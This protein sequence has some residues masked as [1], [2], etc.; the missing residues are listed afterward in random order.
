M[1]G[2]LSS[3][4]LSQ[5]TDDVDS[6]IQNPE[7]LAL[8]RR[9]ALLDTPAEEVFDRLTRLAGKILA[10]PIALVSL[11][12]EDRQFFKSCIGLPEPWSTLRQTPL[13]HSF[14]QHAVATC[15]PLV[16]TDA[17]NEPFICH[18]P[19][20][21]ELG[22]VAYAGIPLLTAEGCALGSFCVIDS[23]PR[24]W[25]KHE[26]EILEDLAA[27]AITAIELRL[28]IAER[29]QTAAAL[30]REVRERRAVATRLSTEHAISHL[31]A[32]ARSFEE[33]ASQILNT[34]CRQLDFEVCGLWLPD[35]QE[36]KLRCVQLG[37][38]KPPAELEPFMVLSRGLSLAEGIA[39]PGCVWVTRK[40]QL[41]V[42][43]QDHSACPRVGVI[44]Q[45]GL[46][47]ALAFP[48]LADA[49]CLGVIDLFTRRK[50][51][52]DSSLIDTV[53]VVG[54]EIG[55]F[56]QRKHAEK[57]LTEQERFVQHVAYLT[58]VVLYVYDL[59]NRQVR[60][61]NRE[62][63]E[64]LGYEPEHLQRMGR[65]MLSQLMHPD[66]FQRFR[67][68]V[69]QLNF[70]QDGKVV[71]FEYRMRH[72]NGRW[73][74]MS[75]RDM[76][77][78]R[79]VDGVVESIVGAAMD[80]TARKANEERLQRS[81]EQFRL[82][83]QAANCG[84]WDWNIR[85]SELQ[86]SGEVEKLAGLASGQFTGTIESFFQVLHPDD[87]TRVWEE[88]EQL[89][90]AREQDYTGQYR[91][92]RPNGEVCWISGR[93]QFSYDSAGAPLRLV[94]VVQ[95]ITLRKTAEEALKQADRQKDE[96]LAMLAHELR[97]PLASMHNA[98]HLL[99]LLKSVDE[100]HR[101]ACAV[102]NRQVEHIT[103][104]VDDLLDVSRIT[105]GKI[106]L[107]RKPLELQTI[108]NRAVEVCRPL[109]DE[110]RQQLTIT[111]PTVSVRLQGDPIRL[112]QVLT[113]LLNNAAKYTNQK[114]HIRLTAAQQGDEV[115]VKVQDTGV[116]ISA[117]MLPYVFDLFA[118]ADL[119][120]ERTQGGLGIG[121]TLVRRLV[122]M[123][124]G[125][126]EVFSAGIDQGSEFVVRLPILAAE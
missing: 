70:L 78:A 55:Q 107:Y 18:N 76:V 75:S 87:R 69:A 21:S 83:T 27:S 8:L 33:V 48:L 118:Q 56:M 110:R 29:R 16:I 63:G 101:W 114:G 67:E 59:G 121:L 123:H 37:P 94:G 11:V 116:G 97:N 44:A 52:R 31:L 35:S 71:E 43:L 40:P 54:N 14:C 57:T 39:L 3:Q 66:D 72:V 86:W 25:T 61:V 47:S 34:L 122:E 106:T 95:D 15:Q 96:F 10:A 105:R 38:E 22:V 26:L 90:A 108:I 109:L 103:R 30:A 92:I 36:K 104:L 42:D 125:S 20:I 2:S 62:V 111:L 23:K 50:V 126:V 74:W 5:Q 17:R 89:M 112:V 46:H 58:P 13:S 99:E 9:T 7:R 84:I 81:E 73:R 77:F 113:N 115:V 93:G 100:R 45:L 53:K 120:L 1:D 88:L 82:A 68:Y 124:G 60:W 119:S 79:S 32:N 28:E 117:A 102:V 12:E 24:A 98:I 4:L 6:V 51:A 64:L 80:I 41:S 65:E 91:F 19:A 49:Q 85:T